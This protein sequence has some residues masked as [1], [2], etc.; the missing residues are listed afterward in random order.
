MEEEWKELKT[1]QR[2]AG[3]KVKYL[4]SNQGRIKLEAYMYGKLYDSE[5]LSIGHGMYIYGKNLLVYHLG[6]GTIYRNIYKLFKGDIPKGYQIHHKD[7]NHFNNDINN[8]ICCTPYEHGCFHKITNDFMN[9]YIPKH[10][11]DDYIEYNNWL[12]AETYNDKILKL[13]YTIEDSK[14]FIFDLYK[15]FEDNALIL[16]KE[17]SLKKEE[18]LKQRQLERQQQLELARQL[19]IESGEYYINNRGRLSKTHKEK[20][21]DERREKTMKTRREIYASKTFRHNV[22][23]GIQNKYNG[24]DGDEYRRKV[25]DGVRKYH[26]NKNAKLLS[27]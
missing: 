4:L 3:P 2:N 6:K 9:G 21:T 22:S 10:N 13:N 5:I 23:V 15:R 25:G 20:W 8:L 24:E 12:N 11:T 1:I 17:Y 26:K 18:A 19:K 14:Q 7:Y 27:N 16:K